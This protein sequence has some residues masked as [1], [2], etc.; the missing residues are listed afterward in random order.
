MGDG[1][2]NPQQVCHLSSP[3]LVHGATASTIE[4]CLPTTAVCDQTS[5][6]A[7]G[8]QLSPP[9]PQY[10]SGDGERSPLALH[11]TLFV[12]HLWCCSVTRRWLQTGNAHLRERI[13]S[14]H[15]ALSLP[16]P[17][18]L[19]CHGTFLGVGPELGILYLL[20]VLYVQWCNKSIWPPVLRAPDRYCRPPTILDHEIS[21]FINTLVYTLYINAF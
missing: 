7:S 16:S 21:R 10:E 20:R 13:A 14:R 6:E 17:H 9:L 8:V 18:L 1:T 4:H 11:G 19:P 3:G 12:H 15:V 5:A 2:Q